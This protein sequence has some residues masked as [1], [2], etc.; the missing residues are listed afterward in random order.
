MSSH[1]RFHYRSLEDL[2]TGITTLQLEIPLS[3][4][5]AVFKQ[6]LAIAGKPVWNRFSVHPMEGFDADPTGAP[7]P[8]AFRRY[9]RY[10]AGGAAVI[11]FEATSVVP[12]ARSN[13]GQFWIHA[14]NIETYA[15]LVKA[16]REAARREFGQEPLLIL[17][18]THSGR[19]SK[20][21]G[22]PQPIIAHHSPILDPIHKLSAAYPLITD[23][24]LDSL[25]DRFVDAAKLAV[26]AGFDGVDVKCCHRYLLSEL[27]ASF[28]RPGKYGGSLE[29][30]TRMLRET[31]TRIRQEVPGVFVTTRLGVF[32]AV[33][34]PYGFGVNR[35]DFRVADLTEPLELIRQLTVLGMPLLNISIGNPYYNPHYGRPFDFPIA[36][37]KPPEEHPLEGVARI[38]TITRQ[39]QERYPDLPVVGTGYA[40]LRQYLPEVAAGVLENRWS[41]LIGQGR[42]SFAYPDSVRD[43]L[44]KGAMDPTKCCVT[45]SACTQIM[46]DGGKTGCVVR[47]SAVYGPQY[48]LARRFAVDR[49]IEE[50]KRC[51]ECEQATCVLGCP[52][53]IDIPA[54]I[55]A[56]ANQDIASAY[57]ILKA[58][59]VLPEM[60]GLICPAAEQC[61]GQCVEKIF[62]ERPIPIQD[63][64]LVV[65]R[66]AR[67][68]GLTGVK[69]P[70]SVGGRPVAIAGGGPGGL[71]CAVR[72]LELGHEVHLWEKS[73]ELGGTP[74]ATIPEE[75]YADSKA[76]VDAILAP[77]VKSGRLVLHLGQRLG[78]DVTLAD[79]RVNHGAVY[80]GFGLSGAS[81]LGEA[82][83]VVDALKFLA[84]VKGGRLQ[85]V[86]DKVAVLGAGN[87]ALDAAVAARRLGARDV[88]IIYRRSFAEMPAWSKERDAAMAAGVHFLVL[89]Q[90]L[91]YVTDTAGN[92]CGV[93]ICR[94]ELG[95]PDASGRRRPVAVPGSEA[96]QAAGLVVEAIGQK[97]DANLRQ[98]LADLKFTKDDLVA[99]K[100]GTQQTFTPGVFA[101]GDI[102]NGGKTAVQAIADGMQAALEIDAF[103]RHQA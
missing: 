33:S 83:G 29:N 74:D 93:R 25:Q 44:E 9:T 31:A 36:G 35:D 102:V 42:G 53:Q 91:G 40:W 8:L 98:A 67:L 18:L 12:E 39:I 34:Y 62:C 95:E 54:F 1:S 49:L 5:F 14:G 3:R 43:I 47:D 17:Q 24:Y 6:P 58:K 13:P 78:P 26:Q 92:V 85:T 37:V 21:Y 61:Q 32:D 88:Y 7:G 63:I 82:D 80:L 75:R 89:T 66:L 65:A 30:R 46:R 20:P 10:A 50:A 84:A 76:E 69:L 73:T 38:I 77:A 97:L 48:R 19:Y 27:L 57:A 68:K 23:D 59:N 28:T 56:F 11:W 16:T 70:A 96:V 103:V 86:P 87:T 72:L 15:R 51:R 55:H 90:P 22:L 79:L 101:G 2:K 99:V 100:K 71:A 52:A 64:Q 60:C 4:K 94:T 41:T 81:T 45:C